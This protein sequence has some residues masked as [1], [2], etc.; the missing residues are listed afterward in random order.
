MLKTADCENRAF[1]E[2]LWPREKLASRSSS[3][4]SL[5]PNYGRLGQSIL[6]AENCTFFNKVILSLFWKFFILEIL[7]FQQYRACSNRHVTESRRRHC[8]WF[9]L[10]H[11][12]PSTQSSSPWKLFGSPAF[13]SV[14]GIF[15]LPFT[16]K[17]FPLLLLRFILSQSTRSC[18]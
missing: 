11:A 15:P 13:H 2:M 17:L 12:N 8:W 18:P 4:S 5:R 10:F 9:H 7:G 1:I 6:F 14:K 3:S 16:M